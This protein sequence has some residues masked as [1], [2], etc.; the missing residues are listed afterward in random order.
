[1]ANVRDDRLNIVLFINLI[2][3]TANL[4]IFKDQTFSYPTS[5]YPCL[6]QCCSVGSCCELCFYVVHE[7]H[8]E[9]ILLIRPKHTRCLIG[10]VVIC[11]QFQKIYQALWSVVYTFY[12]ATCSISVC[13]SSYVFW[14]SLS[15]MMYIVLYV[16]YIN[17]QEFLSNETKSNYINILEWIFEVWRIL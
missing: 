8:V 2:A 6:K 4:V 1:M 5:D 11:R 9:Q 12:T 7:S 10:Y 13:F 15:C 14:I 17:A 3:L 16:C